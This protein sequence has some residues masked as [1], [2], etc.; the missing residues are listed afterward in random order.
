MKDFFAIPKIFKP[1]QKDVKLRNCT[2][3]TPKTEGKD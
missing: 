1:M 3:Y 2:Y